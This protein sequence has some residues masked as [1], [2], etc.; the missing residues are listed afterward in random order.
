MMWPAMWGWAFYADDPENGRLADR[1]G[2]MMGT[3]HHEPM[4]RNHQEYARHRQKWGAW[5]SGKTRP[6]LP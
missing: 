2:V 6:I 4:A 3:S 1:M 5:N